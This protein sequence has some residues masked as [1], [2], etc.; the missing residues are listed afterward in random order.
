MIEAALSTDLCEG[1]INDTLGLYTCLL[2][3]YKF[4]ISN[5]ETYIIENDFFC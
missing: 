5:G 4:F 3:M 2:F 1:A